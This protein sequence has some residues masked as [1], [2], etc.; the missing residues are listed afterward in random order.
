LSPLRKV[1][2]LKNS[3]ERTETV[4]ETHGRTSNEPSALKVLNINHIKK[5]NPFRV[6]FLYVASSTGFTGGYSNL[7]LSGS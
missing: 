4:G 2:K 6:V 7:T 1:G 3:P 5:F